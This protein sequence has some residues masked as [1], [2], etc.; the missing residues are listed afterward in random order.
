MS[1]IRSEIQEEVDRMTEKELLGLKKFLATCP[2]RLGAVFR[3]APWDDEPF[4]D[5][6]RLA[7]A[8]AEEWFEQDGGEGISHDEICRRHRIGRYRSHDESRMDS[9]SRH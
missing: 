3:N 2:S 7:V 4:T 5:E 8:E 9:E 6:E 1:G